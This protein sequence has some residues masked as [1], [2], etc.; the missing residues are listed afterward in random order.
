MAGAGDTKGIRKLRNQIL[1]GGES[2]HRDWLG[3]DARL[4]EARMQEKH[5]GIRCRNPT[6]EG[7]GQGLLA[8]GWGR[9]GGGMPGLGREGM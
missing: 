6:V 7:E 2:A 3:S 1:G 5:T 4:G 8:G 9:A